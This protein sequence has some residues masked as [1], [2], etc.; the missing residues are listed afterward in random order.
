MADDITAKHL[1]KLRIRGAP[2]M[3]PGSAAMVGEYP[4]QQVMRSAVRVLTKP[5][6]QPLTF[7]KLRAGVSELREAQ[8]R[9]GLGVAG[10]PILAVLDDP[11]ETVPHKRKL[12]VML[13]IRGPAKEEGDVKPGRIDG[14]IYVSSRVVGTLAELEDAYTYLLGKFLP[15]RRWELARKQILNILPDELETATERLTIEIAIPGTMKHDA[16]QEGEPN[17]PAG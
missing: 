13:P 11:M 5:L 3:V 10:A 1:A 4:C 14:G 6:E 16:Q 2:A 9:Q 7:E 12:E 17:P 15:S 8:K